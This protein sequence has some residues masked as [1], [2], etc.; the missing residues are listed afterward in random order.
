[1]DPIFLI[2]QIVLFKDFQIYPLPESGFIK[3]SMP[4][5]GAFSSAIR[6]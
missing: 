4:E 5:R 3:E 6:P 2:F 1:M